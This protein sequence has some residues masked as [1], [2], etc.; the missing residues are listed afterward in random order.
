MPDPR[1]C[2]PERA[3]TGVT[4]TKIASETVMFALT[5]NLVFG[6]TLFAAT[7]ASAQERFSFFQPSTPESVERMLKLATCATTT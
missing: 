7:V 1:V 5:R 2:P 3:P 4:L 6:V